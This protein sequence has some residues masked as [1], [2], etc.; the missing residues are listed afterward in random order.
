MNLQ[1]RNDI[2]R[3]VD[4]ELN[5]EVAKL[6]GFSSNGP[7]PDYTYDLNAMR[8]IEQSIMVESD[9]LFEEYVS[10]LV[11]LDHGWYRAVAKACAATARH[12]AEAYVLFK[13][14]QAGEW[15]EDIQVQHGT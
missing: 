5:A 11:S 15:S 9:K 1:V 8:V 3:L 13:R 12:R 2:A 14:K 6:S 7:M 4:C 10:I